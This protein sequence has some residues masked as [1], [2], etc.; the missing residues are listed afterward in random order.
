MFIGQCV[1]YLLDKEFLSLDKDPNVQLFQPRVVCPTPV[2]P[3][4]PALWTPVGDQQWPANNICLA[5]K[6]IF[7]AVKDINPS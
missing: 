1:Q 3:A 6:N 5:T 7:K 2:V 4:V